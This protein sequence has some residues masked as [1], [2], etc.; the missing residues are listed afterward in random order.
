MQDRFGAG[1]ARYIDALAEL[2]AAW[3]ATL[4]IA[5]AAPS[6]SWRR[7][8][9]A[10]RWRARLRRSDPK[11]SAELLAGLRHE[12]GEMAMRQDG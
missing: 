4:R 9:A 5:A 12:L 6:P 1:V 10:W 8:S 3:S 11:L 2:S 7:W